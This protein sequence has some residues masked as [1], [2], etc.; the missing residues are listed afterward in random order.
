MKSKKDIIKVYIEQEVY[1]L[2]YRKN[3]KKDNIYE[4]LDEETKKFI[5]IVKKYDIFATDEFF[6]TIQETVA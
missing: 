3:Y 6:K 4:S 5:D 1:Y 2:Y